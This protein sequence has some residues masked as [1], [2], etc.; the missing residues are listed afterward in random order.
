MKLE[1]K[2]FR[3]MFLEYVEN[4]KGY[5]VFDLERS[6]LPEQGTVI[7]V[8]KDSDEAV[9]PH[10]VER[11]PVMDEL[12][13]ALLPPGRP[14]ATEL[15]LAEYRSPPQ[16]FQ[17]DRL[18]FNP[19]AERSRRSREPVSLLEDGLDANDEP[20]GS[21]VSAVPE[22]SRIDE[23]GLIAD[24]VLA[25][26]ACFDGVPETPNAY[27]EAANS[28][29]AAEWHRAMKAELASHARNSTWT[30]VPRVMATRPTGCRW[31]FA[32]KLKQK[33]G[34][35]FFE[36]YSPVANM[37]SIRVVLPVCVVVAYLMEQLDADTAFL[38]SDLTDRVDTD[39][40]CVLESARDYVCLLNKAIHGLKQAAS[41]WNNTIHCV[42]MRNG[43][44]CCGADQRVYVKCNLNG[45]VD[46]CLLYVD[47]MIIAAKTHAE[48]REV[49]NALKNVYKM[50]ELGEAK[51][52]LGMEI[53]HDKT[54][55]TLM[56]K[57]YRYIDDAVERSNR[58]VAKTGNN[59]YA[60]T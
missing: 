55:G 53:D 1:N 46:V 17:E 44:G 50:K 23:D 8:T 29:A 54:A 40:S 31:V 57:Q 12:M 30:P 59:P 24:A 52:I 28:D 36:T 13:E 43:F 34:V 4:V 58:Q 21:D 42:F 22:A 2:R 35:D 25:N 27:A 6:K 3:C 14:A 18:V 11:Q 10:P 37:N 26:P 45:H 41:A 7:H 19:E 20:E 38:N 5:R 51:L 16:A 33:F 9:V 39:V 48:I 47:D 60:P 32:K 56:I 15:K 49:K